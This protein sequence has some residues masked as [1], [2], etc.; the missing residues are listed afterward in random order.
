MDSLLF[1]LWLVIFF[2]LFSNE[3]SWLLIIMRVEYIF[4]YFNVNIS[5]LLG[6]SFL[7]YL[8]I[9]KGLQILNELCFYLLISNFSWFFSILFYIS[10][11]PLAFCFCQQL[12]WGRKSHSFAICFLAK[13][14]KFFS[15]IVSIGS[16]IDARDIVE[17][18]Q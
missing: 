1:S 2:L 5:E 4:L 15:Q 16:P 18:Y 6:Y 7:K 3:I 9:L 8:S 17:I 12:S 13:W 14:G 11:Q 10:W